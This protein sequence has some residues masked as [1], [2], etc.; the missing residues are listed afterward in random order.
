MS[1]GK[2]KKEPIT[3]KPTGTPGRV[4]HGDNAP[5]GK[6]GRPPP[7]PPSKNKTKNKIM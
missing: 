5:P 4:I 1:N 3:Q 7:P 2:D 6:T